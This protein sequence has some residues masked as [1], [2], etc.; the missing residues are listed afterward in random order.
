[1][2]LFNK[3]GAIMRGIVTQLQSMDIR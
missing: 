2:V 1:M 3:Y